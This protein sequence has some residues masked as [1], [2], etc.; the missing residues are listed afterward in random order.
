MML[1]FNRDY[2]YIEVLKIRE[3]ILPYRPEHLTTRLAWIIVINL[4]TFGE[5]RPVDY[6]ETRY[7]VIWR[8][9]ELNLSSS[10]RFSAQ[11]K[12]PRP[13]I[14]SIADFCMSRWSSTRGRDE[15]PNFNIG[16]LLHLGVLLRT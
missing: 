12:E 4:A 6:W 8:G 3:K 13:V 14:D 16:V 10:S 5:A 15:W 11:R 7:E 2:V 1:W 9:S